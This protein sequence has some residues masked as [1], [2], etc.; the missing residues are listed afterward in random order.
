MEE[1][2]QINQSNTVISIDN[3]FHK[4]FKSIKSK[5]GENIDVELDFLKKSYNS[6]NLRVSH[7]AC[8]TLQDLVASN[9]LDPGAV[10]NILM[11][12]IQNSK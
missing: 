9:L 7:A 10:L 6:D 2:K 11:T 4:V 8:H 12:L 1:I 3:S 5:K